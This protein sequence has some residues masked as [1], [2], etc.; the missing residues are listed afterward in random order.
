M[1][2]RISAILIAAIMLLALAAC[3]GTEI[4]DG[5]ERIAPR[6]GDSELMLPLQ[7]PGSGTTVLASDYDEIYALITEH[8][9]RMNQRNVYGFAEADGVMAEEGESDISRNVVDAPAATSAE[10]ELAINDSIAPAGAVGGGGMDE[11]GSLEF[12]D[13][14]NQVDGVQESDIVK[15]DGRNIYITSWVDNSVNVIAV[16]NGNMELVTKIQHGGENSNI[17]EMLLYDGKLILIWNN[18]EQIEIEPL[19]SEEPDWTQDVMYGYWGD[20]NRWRWVY[21]TIVEVYDT[22]GSFDNPI[23]SYSQTGWYN[24]SRMT[25]SNIYILSNYSPPMPGGFAR[26]DLQYY[27]PS[28]TVNNDEPVFIPAGAIALPERIDWIEY[29]VIGGLDVNQ[30]DMLV[31]ISAHLGGTHLIYVSLN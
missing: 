8:N 14:N 10:P 24:S 18:W 20:W 4:E 19:E 23:S 16:N 15:T 17:R 2:K 9:E 6:G 11:G 28:Y 27:I 3:A 30:S 25:G 7:N 13:T 31:S 26:T 1:K 29:T 21:E 22:N 5:E 12:S